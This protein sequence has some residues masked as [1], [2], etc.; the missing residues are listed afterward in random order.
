M[1]LITGLLTLPLTPVRG[2][3]WV[4]ERLHEQAQ[5]ELGDPATL[6]RRLSEVEAARQAG[7]LGDDE[8]AEQ[9]S[10]LVGL[11]WETRRADEGRK[12]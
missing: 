1:G 9:E 11:L 5:Q 3:V 6:R 4:A 8:A 2:V 7:L 10:Q 12:G